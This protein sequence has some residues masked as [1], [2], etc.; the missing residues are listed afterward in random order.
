MKLRNVA[1]LS[2]CVL[3][4]TGCSNLRHLNKMDLNKGDFNT[5]LARNYRDMANFEAKRH[6][7]KDQMF[8]A[9]KAHAAVDGEM[10]LPTN[11]SA[12]DL[13]HDMIPE[14]HDGR[15]RLMR[16]LDGGARKQ[17]PIMG[18]KAQTSFDHWLEEVEENNEPQRIADCRH[19]FYECLHALEKVMAPL[20]CLPG[21]KLCRSDV[22][23]FKF[24]ST[25]MVADSKRDMGDI[26]ASAKKCQ[27][28]T[29]VGCADA[30]GSAS[31]NMSLSFKRAHKVRNMLIKGGLSHNNVF[32][33]AC[34]RN[35]LPVKTHKKEQ[36]NRR[37]EIFYTGK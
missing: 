14:M 8:F 9:K 25:Q 30:V 13:P 23:Y 6:D 1:A 33:G 35:T 12:H 17:Y 19:R 11:M 22:M 32:V 29:I 2:V 3:F 4:F 15:M 34:A 16:V 10:V 7:P 37:V 18:A 20:A 27:R 36:E 28:L 26:M 5:E 24:G 31:G 21:K